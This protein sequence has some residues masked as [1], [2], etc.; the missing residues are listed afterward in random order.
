MV[1]RR[2]GPLS[3]AKV[4]GLLYLILGFVFGAIISL[5][6]AG[7][8]FFPN[9]A[10]GTFGSMAFGAGAIV[11]LPICYA[12]FG[13]VMTFVMAS[14]FNLIVGITGGIEVDAS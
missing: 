7:G 5:F 9:G 8:S 13:F 14:L 10:G 6:A 11:I 12:V 3:C 2:V 1:I 4:A